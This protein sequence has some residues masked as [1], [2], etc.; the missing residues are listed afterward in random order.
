MGDTKAT[1]NTRSSHQSTPTR[2]SIR[3]CRASPARAAVRCQPLASA[4]TNRAGAKKNKPV[5]PTRTYGT[6]RA[7]HQP[8]ISPRLAG[9]PCAL[10]HHQRRKNGTRKA[11]PSHRQQHRLL[12]HISVQ[13]RMSRQLSRLCDPLRAERGGFYLL[14]SWHRRLCL[15]FVLRPTPGPEPAP[16]THYVQHNLPRPVLPGHIRCGL[17][18]RSGRGTGRLSPTPTAPPPVPSVIVSDP[19]ND[20]SSSPGESTQK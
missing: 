18:G 16:P 15:P 2:P 5:R 1:Q 17:G 4:S 12:P 3:P 6:S 13:G 20:G 10:A 9:P 14:Y 7:R 8:K 11:D 19:S